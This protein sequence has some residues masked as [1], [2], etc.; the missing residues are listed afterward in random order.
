[1]GGII[2]SKQKQVSTQA[3]EQRQTISLWTFPFILINV[4]RADG[5]IILNPQM[6]INQ[7][8]LL[9]FLF[10]YF[11]QDVNWALHCLNRLQVSLEDTCVFILGVS[12]S[13]FFLYVNELMNSFLAFDVIC[14]I[15]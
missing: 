11:I 13:L 4:K 7:I 8:F 9:D 14:E 12:T 10:I 2:D 6:Q 1:M 15:I 5:T 3:S